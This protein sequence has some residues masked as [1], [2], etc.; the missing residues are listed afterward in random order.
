MRIKTNVKWSGP[1]SSGIRWRDRDNYESPLVNSGYRTSYTR[2]LFISFPRKS[3]A[4]EFADSAL[5]RT[6]V[7]PTTATFSSYANFVNMLFSRLRPTPLY[8][9]VFGDTSLRARERA[10]EKEKEGERKKKENIPQSYDN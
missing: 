5:A 1:I 2:Q 6:V 3:F 4:W 10:R 7:R 9:P 8:R